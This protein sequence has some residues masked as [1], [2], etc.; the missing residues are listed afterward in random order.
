MQTTPLGRTG[1]IVSVAGLGCGGPSRLGLSEGYGNTRDHA[2][3]LVRH[4]IDQGVTLIDTATAY[5]NEDVAGR[6]VRE[7]GRRDDIVLSSKLGVGDRTGAD[8][9]AGIDASLQRLGLDHIDLYHVHGVSVA[10]L[11][12]VMDEIVPALL[13]AKSAGK[14]GHLAISERF[15]TEPAHDM[16][17]LL[18]SRDDWAT[19][20][21][22]IMLGHNLLNPSARRYVLPHTIEHGIGTLDMFAVRRALSDTGRRTE[23]LAEIDLPG[24]ALDF[25]GDA[26]AVT[27]AGYRFCRHEPGI[28]VVLF[29]TGNRVHL[30]ANLRA[31]NS[32]PLDPEVRER[33][34][35][36]FGDRETVSGS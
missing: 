3:A 21:E 17:R 5:G 12:R 24:D 34:A 33:L 27:E 2:L 16:A 15:E 19:T 29:G 25:L 35:T 13:D 8:Y 11:P 23:V 18:F 22:V 9:A 1:K 32:P 20:F 4:A 28:D 31:I 30:D 7:S 6:S 10:Q 26:E 14:I 36:L